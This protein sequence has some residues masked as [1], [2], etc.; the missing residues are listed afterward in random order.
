MESV[1]GCGAGWGAWAA[2]G[3][4]K[5]FM[6]GRGRHGQLGQGDQIQSAAAFRTT[7]GVVSYFA[8]QQ[9]KVLE[10]SLGLDH[11]VAIAM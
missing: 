11:T 4:G 8:Q 2:R 5:L 7:P 1:G 9:M 3:W 6:W 10:V